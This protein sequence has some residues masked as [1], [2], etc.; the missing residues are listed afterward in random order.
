MCIAVQVT[1]LGAPAS[2]PAEER[3]GTGPA[4]HWRSQGMRLAA[5]RLNGLPAK[6]VWANLSIVSVTDV[7]ILIWGGKHEG[8]KHAGQT[9]GHR[10]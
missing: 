8:G 2:S 9:G 3:T 6:S 10:L 7:S 4:G 5:L 1:V